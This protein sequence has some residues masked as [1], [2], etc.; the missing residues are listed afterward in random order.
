[1]KKWVI[2]GLLTTLFIAGCEKSV[3]DST[4]IKFYGDAFEDIGYNI[5]PSNGG[6]VIAGQLT[7]ITRSNGNYIESSNKN[8]GIIKISPDGQFKWKFFSRRKIL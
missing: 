1:M 5:I 6:Y 4:I 2:T 7:D 3:D 8:L